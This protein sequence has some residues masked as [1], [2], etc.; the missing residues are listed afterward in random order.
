M[1][2]TLR[3]DFDERRHLGHGKVRLLELIDVHGSISSAAR[4]MGMSY[5][6]AWLLTDEV[7]RMFA[8]PVFATR[9]G[10]KGGGKAQLTQFG[11]SLVDLYRRMERRAED[12][13]GADIA[14]LEAALA[15]APGMEDA[16]GGAI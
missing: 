12:D 3:L 8:E 14:K 15:P 5:R 16:P 9:L 1:R 2:V 7:N 10:G 13:F 11:H 4:A 6:R